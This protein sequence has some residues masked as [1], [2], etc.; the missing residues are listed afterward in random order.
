MRSRSIDAVR[1]D[2][3]VVRT[4]GRLGH[5]TSREIISRLP[6][7]YGDRVCDRTVFRSLV[8]LVDAGVLVVNEAPKR[9]SIREYSIRRDP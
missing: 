2:E 9:S 5:S 8:R 4:I 1:L 6:Y 3:A 7:H